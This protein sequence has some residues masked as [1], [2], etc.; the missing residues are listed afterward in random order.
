MLRTSGD[1]STLASTDFS[2]R[3]R[4][5]VSRLAAALLLLARSS[6][7]DRRR[8]PLARCCPRT[9][10]VTPGP[11]RGVDGVHRRSLPLDACCGSLRSLTGPA[12]KQPRNATPRA[13][14]P[15]TRPGSAGAI[16]APT[17]SS[18]RANSPRAPC[19]V[20][21]RSGSAARSPASTAR[22]RRRVSPGR[23]WAG[24]LCQEKPR[25]LS[26]RRICRADRRPWRRA[27]PARTVRRPRRSPNRED[28]N[29]L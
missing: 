4:A 15:T 24:A 19:A 17:V 3:D 20:S 14:S 11:G 8:G 25:R 16:P 23:Q 29:S 9:F 27:R 2:L 7:H 12:T 22:G 5:I 10:W 13:G 26:R 21:A 28:A 6:H 1:S 18:S